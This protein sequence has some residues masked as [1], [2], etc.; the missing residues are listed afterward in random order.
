MTINWLAPSSNG[1]SPIMG[2]VVTSTPSG[3][4]CSTT[5]F[6]CSFTGLTNGVVLHLHGDRPHRRGHRSQ[7]RDT[8]TP[9]TVP[10]QPTGV[11]GTPGVGQVTLTWLPP[12]SDGGAA[13]SATRVC[14]STLPDM[15][16]CHVR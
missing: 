5:G 12:T 1:G 10:G 3:A 6:S 16:A 9:I 4:T 13:I 15:G 7:R 8:A 2:Y 14:T 11:T